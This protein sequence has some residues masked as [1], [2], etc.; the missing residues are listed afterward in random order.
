MFT[1]LKKLTESKQQENEKNSDYPWINE[2]SEQ[3]H[4]YNYYGEPQSE[5]LTALRD[6]ELN[7]PAP[8][9]QKTLIEYHNFD[10]WG[11]E[12]PIYFQQFKGRTYATYVMNVPVVRIIGA[13][14]TNNLHNYNSGMTY[15][16]V[17]F[18]CLH[19]GGIDFNSLNFLLSEESKSKVMPHRRINHDRKTRSGGESTLN[20]FGDYFISSHGHQL[21][22]LAMYWIWQN[23]GANAS[24]KNVRVTEWFPNF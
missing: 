11:Y 24:L 8:F 14:T 10:A 4:R 21:T 16:D 17:L 9:S 5:A 6:N 15:R 3:N 22:I 12:S 19:G 13:S 2:L 1:L 20:R 23:D 18:Q 7:N